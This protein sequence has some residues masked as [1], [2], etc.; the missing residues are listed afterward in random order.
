MT[1]TH[2]LPPF[3][4]DNSSDYDSRRRHHQKRKMAMLTFWRDGLERQLS[5]I[6]AAIGTLQQQIDR[7]AQSMG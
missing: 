6:N 4:C 2:V 3:C 7:D 5:A 1:V